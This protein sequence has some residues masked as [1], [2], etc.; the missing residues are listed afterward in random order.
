MG[1]AELNFYD[2][3]MD[4]NV[5]IAFA[6][7]ALMVLAIQATRFFSRIQGNEEVENAH[8]YL[9]E[10]KF[11][12]FMLA[13]GAIS[14]FVILMYIIGG[15][16]FIPFLTLNL[17]ITTNFTIKKVFDGMDKLQSNNKRVDN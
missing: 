14:A 16:R 13:A 6:S 12:L 5:W 1:G 8:S 15:V 7:P 9:T 11:Y 17:C 4:V 3:L 2:A 10:W